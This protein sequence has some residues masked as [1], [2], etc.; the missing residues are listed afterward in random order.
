M[1]FGENYLLESVF[2]TGY[3]L[4]HIAKDRDWKKAKSFK[5]ND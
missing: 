1:L 2:L 5:F 4:Q 3:T